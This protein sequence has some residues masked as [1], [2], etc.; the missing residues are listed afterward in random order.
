MSLQYIFPAPHAAATFSVEVTQFPPST[1]ERGRASLDFAGSGML[2]AAEA[3]L[4]VVCYE[5]TSRESHS[6]EWVS[7]GMLHAPARLIE[8]ALRCGT[9]TLRDE[10]NDVELDVIVVR[11]EI[12][13]CEADIMLDDDQCL[14]F[15][16]A[17]VRARQPA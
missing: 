16:S 8:Q 14:S 10:A 4:G 11:H 5:I 13:A 1:S 7:A 2:L 9:L 15:A 12:G 6:G 3:A 17:D